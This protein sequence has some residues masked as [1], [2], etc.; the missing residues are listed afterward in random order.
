MSQKPAALSLPPPDPRESWGLPAFGQLPS[1]VELDELTTRVIANNP[2][3]LTLDGT[4]TYVVGAAGSGSAVIIDPG[5]SLEEH[6]ET[7]KSVLAQHDAGCAYILVTH[8]HPDHAEAARDWAAF[9]GCKIAAFSPEVA[10]EDGLLIMDGTTIRV[11]ELHIVTVATPG[12]CDDHL[13]FSLS[14]GALLTGDHIL[15]RGTAMVAWPEGR[16][17]AYLS[18]L[19]KVASMDPVALYPG[20]GPEL[21]QDPLAVIDFYLDHRKYRETQILDAL[22]EGTLA[23]SELVSLIYKEVDQ[24]LWPAAEL[25]TRAALL[26]LEAE[27]TVGSKQGKYYLKKEHHG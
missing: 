10:G 2:S 17:D 4:N 6:L 16:M 27:G 12:H 25:S 14:N 24:R 13:S 18:S 21:R 9:F 8:H 20:H 19:R 5:P 26:K 3:P 11:G 22:S 23:P 1:V 7:T 15:G